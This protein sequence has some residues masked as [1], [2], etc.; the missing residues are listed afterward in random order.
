LLLGWTLWVARRCAGGLR[1]ATEDEPMNA[2]GP[3]LPLTQ[4]IPEPSH[5]N[6]SN[7]AWLARPPPLCSRN[8]L[9]EGYR[10]RICRRRS[11]PVNGTSKAVNASEEITRGG[12]PA[13]HTHCAEPVIGQP[14]ARPVG[15][16]GTTEKVT[17]PLAAPSPRSSARA[18]HRRPGQSVGPGCS[19]NPSLAAA[20]PLLHPAPIR[21]PS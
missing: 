4:V 9:L 20:W 12:A 2:P 10:N 8:R 1:A 3:M 13:A 16:A 7:Y 19:R 5:P 11:K 14:I 17:P 18:A 6:S 15:S 21:R